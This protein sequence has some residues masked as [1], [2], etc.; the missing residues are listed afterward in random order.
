M[1][2]NSKRL[3]HRLLWVSL[4]FAAILGPPGIFEREIRS[5]AALGATR[6]STSGAALDTPHQYTGPGACSST[7][8]H[9]SIA[10]LTT[11]RV[12]QN[13]YSIW[14]VRDKHAKAYSALTGTV[15]ERIGAILK[16]G[17]SEN[18]PRCLACH[19]LDVPVAE[20]ART[21]DMTEGVSC[22]S[23][24]GPAAAWLG[25]HTERDWKHEDSVAKL[26]MYDTRDIVK[27]TE[28]CLSCHLG[29]DQKSVDH[30]MIAAGHPDLYF[31]LDSFSAQMP[32]HWKDN[33]SE[34]GQPDGSDAW[35]DMREWATG[36][37]VQLN[38]ALVH[39]TERTKGDVWPEYSEMECYACHHSL[40]PAEQSWEQARGYGNR[41]PGDPPWNISRYIVLREI[42][43]EADEGEAQKL[44][45]EVMRVNALM[46]T[47]NPK[48]EEVAAAATS[49]AQVA[50]G[51]AR[52]LNSMQYNSALALHL[53]QRISSD[54]DNISAQ[55]W[56][57][58]AQA[59]M[60][61][62]SLYVAY[63]R[64]QK[65]QDSAQLRTAIAGL[66]E[67]LQVPSSYDATRFS[68]QM[69]NVNALLH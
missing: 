18:A 56:H 52:K 40:V 35:F 48:R 65:F 12:K 2:A 26:G 32:R 50:G 20:R 46:S 7:T 34:P 57:C 45:V 63:D 43:R 17:K 19:A 61:M 66:F 22:E 51:I 38:R 15:G 1:R 37:A 33:N 14:I 24:H 8:C 53:L 47:L 36:Q 31:E 55:G 9:G 30:E 5:G 6:G 23:C 42:V 69:K 21:F 49:S 62:Q 60:A 39:L 11:N 4:T 25:P 59:A 64:N 16:L 3:R 28:R 67:Q 44:D 54:S 13:E 58:A 10:P 29:N 41:R 68:R 27:R